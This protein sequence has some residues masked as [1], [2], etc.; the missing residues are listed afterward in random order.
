M[1]NLF[2]ALLFT[3]LSKRLQEFTTCPEEQSQMMVMMMYRLKHDC[4][5]VVVRGGVESRFFK[6]EH[7]D[8]SRFPSS[9]KLR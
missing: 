3:R 1:V 5:F 8:F 4:F 7:Q 6:R 2:Y 9:T